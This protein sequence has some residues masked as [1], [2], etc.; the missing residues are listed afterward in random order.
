MWTRGAVVVVK[1]GDLAIADTACDGLG[2]RTVPSRQIEN[3]ERDNY[4]LRRHS[5]KSTLR[6]I[7]RAEQKYGR[8]P[9]LPMIFKVPLVAYGMIVYGIDRLYDRCLD[10]RRHE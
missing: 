3:L 5:K 4:F 8:N 1:R 10:L 9:E 7:R 2:L 6:T